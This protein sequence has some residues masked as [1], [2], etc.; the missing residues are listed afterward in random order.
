MDR[1]LL[2]KDQQL[3]QKNEKRLGDIERKQLEEKQEIG[4]QV[5]RKIQEGHN[6]TRVEIDDLRMRIGLVE[7]SRREEQ[8]QVKELLE[9]SNE[10]LRR[11][12]GELMGM[13]EGVDWRR[14]EFS[15]LAPTGSLLR[16]PV[17]RL[18]GLP[19]VSVQTHVQQGCGQAGEDAY[20]RERFEQ[21]Q[22]SR[23]E[24]DQLKELNGK[25][26]KS[27][28]EHGFPRTHAPEIPGIPAVTLGL[29]SSLPTEFDRQECEIGAPRS[30]WIPRSPF[31][32]GSS[33][34]TEFDRQE[35]K[36][37]LE[38]S[39]E[40][41]L[42]LRA[43]HAQGMP[44]SPGGPEASMDPTVFGSSLPTEFDWQECEIGAPRPLWIPRSPLA[45]GSSLS[46][47]FDR[48]EFK[49]KLEKSREKSLF[50]RALHA[51]GMP[52]SPG[53]PEAS[54]DPTVF[55]SSLPTEFDRQECEIGAP[56]PPWIP[57]SPLALGSSLSTEFDRQEFKKKLEKSREKSLFLRALHAQ[58]MPWSPGGPEA[59][60]DP[61]VFGS[62]LPT[63]F[64]RQECE[65]GAPRPPWIPRSPWPLGHPSLNLNGSSMPVRSYF[66]GPLSTDMSMKC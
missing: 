2:D 60:M 44:W 20:P 64:D 38:K 18:T 61:T 19:K 63:E 43:L 59:S 33:L 30:P 8:V 35:F 51:Q 31:A 12:P 5:D 27:R 10:T 3:E 34:S 66:E 9:K 54:M 26:E 32:L 65:I 17:L 40:K 52:W 14:I 46:T 23:K 47:E 1:W 57:R 21:E 58:G 50:L 55:G 49:K 53:G 45:L 41:S 24:Q 42:F 25:L 16:M 22:T 6:Q 4:R 62:S 7:T 15:R 56:R 29:G 13:P 39:R 28:E 36:K 37:K 11:K 48:Q